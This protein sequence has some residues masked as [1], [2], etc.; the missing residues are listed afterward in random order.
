ME[1]IACLC[2]NIKFNIIVKGKKFFTFCPGCGNITELSIDK[3]LTS[4]EVLKQLQDEEC[5]EEDDE[6]EM[7]EKALGMVR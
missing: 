4:K 7:S 6:E 1:S 3:V 2:G 5:E